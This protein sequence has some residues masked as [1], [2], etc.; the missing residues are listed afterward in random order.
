MTVFISYNHADLEFVEDLAKRLVHRR[1]HI[2][3]DK[4]EL[5]I[6]DSLISNIQKV[7]D[8]AEAILIILSKASVESEWCKRELNSGLLRELE[9][10][11]ILILPC[12]IDDC[13]VPLFLRDKLYA[14]FRKD[15]DKAFAQ[16]ND[17]LL[18]VA[19][20]QQGRL[21]SPNFFTDWS[22]DWARN[23]MTGSWRFEWQFVEHGANIEY[24]V[25]T[26]LIVLCDPDASK[27]FEKL[28]GPARQDYIRETLKNISNRTT[29]NEIK[30]RLSDA[31]RKF[32]MREVVNGPGKDEWLVELS[33][34]RMGIDNGK[35]TLVHVDQM[36]E[37]AL[38]QM[39][40]KMNKANPKA[41]RK[42]K[43]NS[44]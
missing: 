21:E 12:V 31:F 44:D 5:N 37:R 43:T 7:L 30:I 32:G 39:T 10:K 29:S 17:A 22:Y 4:W 38:R 41:S 13:K 16:I 14:D 19:N 20:L 40:P 27:R 34:K 18:K 28:N 15:K 36:L 25:L 24:C 26:E 23:P 33:S 6:G 3:I 11:R 8:E 42:K 35:D 1:H 2:W 9:E